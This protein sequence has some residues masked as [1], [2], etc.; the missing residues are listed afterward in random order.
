MWVEDWVF[1][2]GKVLVLFVVF[3]CFVFVGCFVLISGNRGLG[4][5]GDGRPVWFET[6]GSRGIEQD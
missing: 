1:F 2:V 4:E 5:F 3:L 6:S